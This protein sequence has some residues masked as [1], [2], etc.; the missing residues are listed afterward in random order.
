MGR[1]PGI[2]NTDYEAKRLA[3]LRALYPSLMTPEGATMSFRAMAEAAGISVPTLRHYFGSREGVVEASLEAASKMG[4]QEHIERLR[5]G[6]SELDLHAS[7]HSAL[8]YIV[9]GWTCFGVGDLHSFG[10]SAGLSDESLGI[11]YI[12]HMLEPMLQA[13]EGRLQRHV[14]RGELAL[15][16]PRMA[17]LMLVSPVILA[18]LHQQ[19]LCGAQCRPLALDAL[20]EENV[21]RFVRAYAP[22][23]TTAD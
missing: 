22:P 3:I 18:L 6:W 14:E 11:A 8:E 19:E 4:G 13:L 12:S 5:S 15:D 20:L 1:T 10:L 7:L 17:T 21:Y 23:T 9:V 16:D 2:R